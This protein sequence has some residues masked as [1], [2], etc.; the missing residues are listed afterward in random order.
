M[1]TLSTEVGSEEIEYVKLEDASE[2]GEASKNLETNEGITLVSLTTTIEDGDEEFDSAVIAKLPTD[3]RSDY[4]TV[5][6]QLV[7]NN[8]FE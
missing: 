8:P 7:R 2:F 4:M 1:I 3:L 6:S 5:Q